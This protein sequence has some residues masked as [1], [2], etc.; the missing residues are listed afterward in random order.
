MTPQARTGK[1]HDLTWRRRDL[2]VLIVLA[3]AAGAFLA[4]RAAS[5]P[6][7]LDPVLR[8][9][10]PRADQAIE[11]IDPNVASVHSLRRLPKIGPALAGAIVAA[12]QS[13]AFKDVDDL[14]LRVSGIGPV[15]A[16][17]IAPFLTFGQDGK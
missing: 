13:G 8:G 1:R 16:A 3:L 6:R 2:A 7:D 11:R 5:Q 9:A 4:E 14:R 15:T 17:T 12:R 10:G